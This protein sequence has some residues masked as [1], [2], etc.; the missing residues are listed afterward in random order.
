VSYKDCHFLVGDDIFLI[1]FSDLYDLFKLNV[2]DISNALLHIVSPQ[3]LD[4]SIYSIYVLY[5]SNKF[6]ILRVG[7]CNNK[8]FIKW[9]G[10]SCIS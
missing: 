6:G 7:T 3:K 10:V 9:K 5:V 1:S 4:S 2:L 8:H